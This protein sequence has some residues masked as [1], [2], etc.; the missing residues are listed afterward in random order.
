VPIQ[1]PNPHPKP[2]FGLVACDVFTDEIEALI[3]RTRAPVAI[4]YLEM[5]LHD[6]P[7]EL[8]RE[9]QAAIERLETAAADAGENRGLEAI[10]LVYG[11]CG[12]GLAGVTANRVPLAI[13]RA[14]DC[15]AVMLGGM[16][17]FQR[18]V[19]ENPT[20]YF[21]SPG[22]VRGRRVPGPDRDA[23]LR[24]RF[25]E[26]YPDDPEMVED[27]IEADDETYAHYT[28]AG[29]VDL[30]G[31]ADADAY[32]RRCAAQ[33]GWEYRKLPGDAAML[34][35]LLRGE[36]D[37]KRFLIVPPGSRIVLRDDERVMDAEPVQP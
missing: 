11:L 9:I 27:L 5:G 2:A 7:D 34:T 1:S 29:Y 37:L 26:R 20:T 33:K 24:E 32:C 36:W 15:I 14:H 8:R 19:R 28:C 17:A 30:V 6:R 12:S 35:D 10:A 18:V 31:D 4:E 16:P 22:W 21:Y 23:W 13:P 25:N 3:E